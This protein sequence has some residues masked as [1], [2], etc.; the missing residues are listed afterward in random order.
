[1]IGAFGRN[2]LGNYQIT[3]DEAMENAYTFLY[4]LHVNRERPLLFRPT[5]LCVE[6]DKYIKEMHANVRAG[7]KRARR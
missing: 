6:M 4:G 5:L 3:Q 1:M 2:K 7:K